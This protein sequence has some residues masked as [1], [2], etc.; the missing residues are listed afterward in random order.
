MSINRHKMIFRCF[1]NGPPYCQ[2][3]IVQESLVERLHVPTLP[4][5]LGA[6][7]LRLFKNGLPL[8][9]MHCIARNSIVS[10]LQGGIWSVGV[11]PAHP[12]QTTLAKQNPKYSPFSFCITAIGKQSYSY[13][14][15]L[16]RSRCHNWPK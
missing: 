11:S 15:Q 7:I 4:P 3:E 12:A 13:L 5:Q 8:I 6:L 1:F 14:S 10:S 16:L 2:Q 9:S